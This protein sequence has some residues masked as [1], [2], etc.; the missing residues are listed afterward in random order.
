MLIRV[1]T[2]IM[3][4]REDPKNGKHAYYEV[5][6]P[7]HSPSYIKPCLRQ[8]H[9]K[10]IENKLECKSVVRHL[11]WWVLRGKEFRQ[12]QCQPSERD[13]WKHVHECRIED[14]QIPPD[15]DLAAQRTL[16]LTADWDFELGKPVPPKRKRQRQ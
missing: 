6:C 10:N 3:K 7:Y 5:K 2:D 9:V 12:C 8:R 16:E 1:H 13:R 14:G 15:R 11:K 4:S